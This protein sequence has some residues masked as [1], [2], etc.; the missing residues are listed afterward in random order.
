[1]FDSK[2]VEQLRVVQPQV[3]QPGVPPGRGVVSRFGEGV[4]AFKTDVVAGTLLEADLQRVVPG[5]GIQRRQ[6]LE[7]A[8]KLRVGLEQE[9]LWNGGID[10][11]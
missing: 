5:V 7:A 1:M 6:P 4:V 3:A 11:A 10:V 9:T 8:I 2:I